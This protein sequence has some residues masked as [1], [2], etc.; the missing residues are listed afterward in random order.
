MKARENKVL[1]LITYLHERN[2]CYELI[3]TQQPIR[4]VKDGVKFLDIEAGQ[5]APT[6][7]LN[8]DKG[9]YAAIISGARGKID[10]QLIAKLLDCN[11]IAMADKAEVCK[12]TGYT[13]GSIPLAGHGLP[14]IV[15]R[16]LLQYPFIYGGSGDFTVTLLR[17][18]IILIPLLQN[19]TVEDI[20]YIQELIKHEISSNLI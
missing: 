16:R 1:G 9:F 2:I 20:Y 4:S 12:V 15:D 19:L 13:P 10:L 6:L 18:C 11:T 14:C 3:H 17:H 5:T 8:S 7:V